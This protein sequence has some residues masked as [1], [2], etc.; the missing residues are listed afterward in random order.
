[1][2]RKLDEC[3]RDSDILWNTTTTQA[4]GTHAAIAYLNLA[5]CFYQLQE[6][7][8]TFD[9]ATRALMTDPT[10]CKAHPDAMPVHQLP[11]AQTAKAHFRRGVALCEG[12]ADYRAGMADLE[13]AHR[14][15]PRDLG[16][17]EALTTCRHWLNTHT[18]EGDDDQRGCS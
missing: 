8:K 17:M 1:M 14:L 11:S 16:I 15:S 6:W 12:Y 5:G 9:A 10:T 13:K 2:L 18:E 7:E 4:V 3:K